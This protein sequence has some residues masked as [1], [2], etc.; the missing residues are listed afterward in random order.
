[1]GAEKQVND[2]Q[3]FAFLGSMWNCRMFSMVNICWFTVSL[4]IYLENPICYKFSLA[5]SLLYYVYFS[6]CLT[7]V[8]V[9][10][11][12]RICIIR[13]EIIVFYLFILLITCWK[14]N[15]VIKSLIW[16]WGYFFVICRLFKK[17]ENNFH[18]CI[19]SILAYQSARK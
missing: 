14:Q 10:C 11:C 8:L 19:W 6:F 9:K 7:N 16:S 4:H 12:S 5:C 1:M 2:K 15:R 18:G 3:V 13:S 17:R